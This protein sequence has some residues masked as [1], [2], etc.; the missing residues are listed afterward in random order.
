MTTHTSSSTNLLGNFTTLSDSTTEI[1]TNS[2]ITTTTSGVITSSGSTFGNITTSTWSPVVFPEINESLGL[3]FMQDGEKVFS[4]SSD[5][6]AIE[7]IIIWIFENT[8]GRFFAL[9]TSRW[10]FE[11]KEDAVAFKLAFKGHKLID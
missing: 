4:F 3:V 10:Y 7:A 5:I 9:G 11:L 1:L 6:E 8:T 2:A